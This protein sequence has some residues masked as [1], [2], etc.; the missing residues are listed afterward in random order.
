MERGEKIEENN[1]KIRQYVNVIK[2][3]PID[4][5]VQQEGGTARLLDTLVDAE[6]EEAAQ[7]LELC[8]AV[9][10]M[11]EKL[12]PV[13]ERYLCLKFG[14]ISHLQ[15]TTDLSESD[16]LKEQLRQTLALMRFHTTIE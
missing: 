9:G 3:V 1:E 2:L 6:Q 14:I 10:K 4:Q 11:L 5:P 8:M 13:T 16:I 7:E 15:T 12:D